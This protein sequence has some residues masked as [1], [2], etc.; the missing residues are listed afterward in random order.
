MKITRA[1]LSVADK[2]GIADFARGLHDLGVEL[3]STGGTAEAVRKAGVPTTD[4]SEITGFPDLFGGRVKTLH[5]KIHG[6]VLALR[7][8]K[9]HERQLRQ[10]GIKPIDLVCVNLYPFEKTIASPRATLDDALENIDV[11]GPALL[12]AAAK[13]FKA[14]AAVCNPV[15]YAQVLSE[16]RLHG[17]RLSEHTRR[18]LALEAFAHTAHYDAVIAA[19]FEGLGKP[20]FPSV[21]SP[22]FEK[23]Q[24]LRYGENP[25]QR[26]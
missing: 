11:G 2:S 4:V 6:G 1:L 23:V 13:N 3:I 15:R 19:Y 26:G 10:Q 20:G 5:P 18:E 12:R 14:V 17:C 7:G 22:Y 25:H 8:N 24:E 21:Y 16:L 9:E